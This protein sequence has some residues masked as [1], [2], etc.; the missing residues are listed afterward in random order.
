[1]NYDLICLG[2]LTIDD[3]VLP[4]KTEQIGCF[5]GD[6]IYSALGAACWSEQVG[7]VS[8][9]GN[10]FPEEHLAALR[11][12]GWDT[13]GLPKRSIPSIRNWVIY[14]D[15]N[16][17]KWVLESNPDDF[18]ELSPTFADIPVDYLQSRAFML[19]AMDLAAQEILASSLRKYGLVAVDP[20]EDYI[21]GNIER[22]L[23]MLKNVDIFTPSQVEVF[24]LLGHHDY[25]RAC[26]EFA[27]R[28]PNVVVIKMG[29]EGSL[30]Y[31]HAKD[32]FWQIPI[33]NTKVVDTTGAGDAYCGGF[34]A[35]YI[36]TGDLLQAGLA[37]AVSSSYAIEGAGLMQMF[38]I[39][40]REAQSRF[41]QLKALVS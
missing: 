31:D 6:I 28:G 39:D 9:V 7:F 24:R 38:K 36:K 30:I 14:Q 20:Q 13:K 18:F 17:R 34:M 11:A 27:A 2:N 21:E 8:P 23:A 3:V 25:Q 1:V 35:M 29:S 40:K 37:G 22:I 16:H 32:H 12:S 41:I 10:D 4:D 15:N 5:G 26:R 33:Y 19:L